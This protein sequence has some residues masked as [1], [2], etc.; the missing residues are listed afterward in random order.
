MIFLKVRK[1]ISHIIFN[2]KQTMTQRSSVEIPEPEQGLPSLRSPYGLLQWLSSTDH[3]QLG[4]MYLWMALFFFLLG[5]AEALLMRLQLA[6]P[7][8]EFLAPKTYNQLFTIAVGFEDRIDGVYC[9]L[10]AEAGGDFSD[11]PLNDPYVAYEG[12]WAQ[13]EYAWTIP[14][15]NPTYFAVRSYDENAD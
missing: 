11:P 1:S 2:K 5:G 13:Q 9:Y 6:W 12:C 14:D 3:K 10:D 15:N 8:L 4:I 7:E